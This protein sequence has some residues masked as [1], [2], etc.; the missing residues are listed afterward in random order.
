[1]KLP[2][3]NKI[4]ELTSYIIVVRNLDAIKIE[5]KKMTNINTIKCDIHRNPKI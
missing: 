1:M 4:G 3:N 5:R 2:Q